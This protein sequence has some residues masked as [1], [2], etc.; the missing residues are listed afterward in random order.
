MVFLCLL[1]NFDPTTDISVDSD[2]TF[3]I[4]DVAM[5]T[6]PSA[7]GPS[8]LRPIRHCNWRPHKIAP[9]PREFSGKDEG[10]MGS[11]NHPSVENDPDL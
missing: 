6:L 7:E 1:C 10:M 5:V 4:Q 9:G 11:V 3:R 2:P 8:H